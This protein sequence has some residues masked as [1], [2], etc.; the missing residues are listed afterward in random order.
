MCTLS[1]GE[2]EGDF[3]DDWE[4]DWDWLILTIKALSVLKIVFMGINSCVTHRVLFA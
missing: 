4:G 2:S 3:D 1:F